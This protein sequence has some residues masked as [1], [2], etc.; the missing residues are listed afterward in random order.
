M[1]EVILMMMRMIMLLVYHVLF[2]ELNG[3]LNCNILT[4]DG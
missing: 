2:D 1:M 3:V 4:L